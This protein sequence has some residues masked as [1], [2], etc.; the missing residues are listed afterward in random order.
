VWGKRAAAYLGFASVLAACTAAGYRALHPSTAAT[1]EGVLIW[2]SPKPLTKPLLPLSF[3]AEKKMTVAQW[4]AGWPADPSSAAVAFFG[5]MIEMAI[6]LN[7]I[8]DDSE[9]PGTEAP[10]R[11]GSDGA[12]SKQAQQL[13]DKGTTLTTGTTGQAGSPPAEA[14]GKSSDRDARAHGW[15]ERRHWRYSHSYRYYHHRRY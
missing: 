7:K 1:P 13:T 11:P 4:S 8:D 3:P 12:A 14:A 6:S 10:P 5:D 15:S 2:P 9:D